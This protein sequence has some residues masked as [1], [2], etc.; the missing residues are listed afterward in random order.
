M[1]KFKRHAL[2]ILLEVT[3]DERAN[4]NLSPLKKV[5]LKAEYKVHKWSEKAFAQAA[6]SEKSIL[7]KR[8]SRRIYF[9]ERLK[10]AN[11]N[12]LLE[13]E[14]LI[15]EY[16]FNYSYHRT[17]TIDILNFCLI[18]G[19]MNKILNYA[20]SDNSYISFNKRWRR[21]ENHILPTLNIE[22]HKFKM[23]H[24]YKN[25]RN[26][27]LHGNTVSTSSEDRIFLNNLLFNMLKLDVQKSYPNLLSGIKPNV[28]TKL[29]HK[30]HSLINLRNDVA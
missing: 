9:D 13:F 25:I 1:K 21:F 11:S 18:E 28:V 17:L 4:L 30:H 22:F 27:L 26:H 5:D 15:N 19:I 10:T 16:R 12:T 6:F 2:K 8:K 23:N 29:P 14:L 20:P 3:N 24:L 7:G